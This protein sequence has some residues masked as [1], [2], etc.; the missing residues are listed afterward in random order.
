MPAPLVT[1]SSVGFGRGVFNT[2]EAQLQQKKLTNFSSTYNNYLIRLSQHTEHSQLM[3]DHT[4]SSVFVIV[5]RLLSAGE[6]WYSQQKC[7]L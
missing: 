4:A 5:L 3:L 7:P 1:T 6:E 2:S